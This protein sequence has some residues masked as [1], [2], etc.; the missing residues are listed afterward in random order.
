[1][2]AKSKTCMNVTGRPQLS[3][4]LLLSSPPYSI[5]VALFNFNISTHAWDQVKKKVVLLPSSFHLF[6]SCNVPLLWPVKSYSHPCCYFEFTLGFFLPRFCMPCSVCRGL[7]S[8]VVVD[9]DSD[10]LVGLA[11]GNLISAPTGT[12]ATWWTWSSSSYSY[13]HVNQSTIH[14]NISYTQAFPVHTIY[15][16]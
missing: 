1:M 5:F 13:H 8:W 3:R 12:P 4:S 11:R 14:W 2:L 7:K 16:N 15:T 9:G 10:D 6:L